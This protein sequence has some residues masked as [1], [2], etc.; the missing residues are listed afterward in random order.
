MAA[1][2][3]NRELERG[4]TADNSRDRALR[5]L[6]W[7]ARGVS[8]LIAALALLV[9]S[10]GWFTGSTKGGTPLA[11]AGDLRLRDGRRVPSWRIDRLA[12][13]RE[14]LRVAVARLWHRV[15]HLLT[16]GGYISYAAVASQSRSLSVPWPIILTSGLGWGVSVTLVPSLLLLFPDGKLPSP[17]WRFVAWAYGATGVLVLM[18]AP[19]RPGWEGI[20]LGVEGRAGEA[21]AVVTSIGGRGCRRAQHSPGAL[22]GGV[23]SLSTWRSL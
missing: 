17:R 7:S 23:A 13:P 9:I 12:P 19:F 8:L 20:P 5:W 15:R 21:I 10:L 16:R 2:A 18:L 11:G 6:A 3:D 1:T 4:R 22:P 14:P